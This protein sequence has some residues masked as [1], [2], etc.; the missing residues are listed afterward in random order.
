MTY[1]DFDL[2]ERLLKYSVGIIDLVDRLPGTRS[3][4]H[5]AGQLLRSGNSPLP[6]H[7]EAQ[8]AE[9]RNDF[10]HK[11]R[12]C[13]KELREARR[14]LRLIHRSPR[15]KNTSQ[16]SSLIEETEELIKIFFTSI[17]TA[18]RKTSKMQLP[19]PARK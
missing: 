2:E 17:R 15:M 11:M 16:A 19:G 14:W 13:L 10:I 1:A 6:N 3:A 8:A 18:A 7:G 5:V 12:I 4:G 9:S